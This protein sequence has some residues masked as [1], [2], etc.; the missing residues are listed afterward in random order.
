MKE[1]LVSIIKR[2]LKFELIQVLRLLY[3]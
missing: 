3:Y 2:V 1:F